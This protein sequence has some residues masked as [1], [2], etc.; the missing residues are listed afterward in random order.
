PEA[1]THFSDPGLV[2]SA[3]VDG[4]GVA[5][6]SIPLVAAE[7]HAGRLAKPFDIVIR[8]AQAYYLVVP[9]AIADRP[10]VSIFRRWLVTE[11]TKVPEN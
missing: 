10:I 8:R 11:A 2:L 6:A 7:V 1:G 9:E 4:V 5:L 3:A